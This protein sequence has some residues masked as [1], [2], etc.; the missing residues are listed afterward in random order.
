[1][2]NISRFK[3]VKI[4][5]YQLVNLRDTTIITSLIAKYVLSFHRVKFYWYAM[6]D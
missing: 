4:G 3:N 5:L 2:H 6:N 1:M